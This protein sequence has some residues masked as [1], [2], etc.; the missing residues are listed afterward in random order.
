MTNLLVIVESGYFR[1]GLALGGMCL[2]I[3]ALLAAWRRRSSPAPIGGFLITV[4]TMAAVELAGGD[5]NLEP[6]IAWFGLLLIFAFA[7]GAS[8]LRLSPELTA[9]ATIP[10][11]VFVALAAPG[12]PG[13]VRG[14]IVVSVPL[15]G[16]LLDD[17]ESRYRSTGLGVVFFGLASAGTFLAVPDTELVR[18]LFAVSLPITFLAW[19]RVFVSIGRP[20]AYALI[21][22]FAMFTATGAIE[23]TASVL[24]GMAC[25]GFLAMEP[26]YV[27]WKPRMEKLRDIIRISPE[28]VVVLSIPQAVFVFFSSRVAAHFTSRGKAL[29]VVLVLVLASSLAFAWIDRHRIPATIET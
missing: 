24:G 10:G 14:A 27:R 18:T 23:R 21:A 25:L 8:A 28:T 5:R 13:W 3:V 7:A 12:T 15:A 29:A 20:G 17:F 2:A 9:V 22:V 4:A 26:L 19:P 11:A 6:S 1:W 16:F